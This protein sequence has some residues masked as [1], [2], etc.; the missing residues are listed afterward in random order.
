MTYEEK[1]EKLRQKIQNGDIE[2]FT[3]EEKLLLKN[4]KD[5]VINLLKYIIH[6]D[7]TM[8][9]IDQISVLNDVEEI[10]DKEIF[11][12]EERLLFIK[13]YIEMQLHEEKIYSSSFSTDI[14]NSLYLPSNSTEE[15]QE[16]FERYLDDPTFE[17]EACELD[18]KTI[19]SLLD[20][21]RYD[22]LSKTNRGRYY[23]EPDLSPNCIERLLTEFPTDQYPEPLF[24]TNLRIVNHYNYKLDT[25]FSKV[26]LD[27][28]ILFINKYSYYLYPMYSY[29]YGQDSDISVSEEIY[30]T[31]HGN[32]LAS[33]VNPHLKEKLLAADDLSFLNDIKE[34]DVINSIILE[35]F[36]DNEL[37][38]LYQKGFY[39]LETILR[40]Q[41]PK[42]LENKLNEII[43][44]G[45]KIPKEI[46]SV[47]NFAYLNNQDLVLKVLDQ[48]NLY[49][50]L[51]WMKN[52]YNDNPSFV[53]ELELKL[54]KHVQNNTEAYKE[55]RNNLDFNGYITDYL[56]LFPDFV[57]ETLGSDKLS[58]I[59]E[60]D[61]LSGFEY[62]KRIE[63]VKRI[64]EKNPNTFLSGLSLKTDY[65]ILKLCADA[66]MYD[67]VISSIAS[68]NSI[69]EEHKKDYIEMILNSL[70]DLSIA[71]KIAE[72]YTSLVMLDSSITEFFLSQDFTIGL[73]LKSPNFSTIEDQICT[74]DTFEK[75]KNNIAKNNNIPISHLEKME[76]KFGPNIIKYYKDSKIIDIL[77]LDDESFEKIMNLFPDLQLTLDDIHT[78]Y[79]ALIEKSFAIEHPEI[80]DIGTLFAHAI[81][82]S[83]YSE[84][85]KYKE[86]FIKETRLDYLQSFLKKENLN[87]IETTGELIDFIIKLYKN[88][89]KVRANNYIHEL[90]NELI[91]NS[92]T[93]YRNY[94]YL[95][96][97]YYVLENLF[98]DILKI[99]DEC[100]K[101]N[102]QIKLFEPN[103]NTNRNGVFGTPASLGAPSTI[104]V[105]GSYERKASFIL[106]SL[107]WKLEIIT[108]S[109]DRQFFKRLEK[110]YDIPEEYK[111]PKAFLEMVCQKIQDP[112]KRNKYLP[113][114]R[115][116]VYYHIE[117]VA[118]SKKAEIEYGRELNLPYDF[119]PKNVQTVMYKYI[120]KNSNYC[121]LDKQRLDDYIIKKCIEAGMEERIAYDCMNYYT[122]GKG[123][124]S[125]ERCLAAKKRIKDFITI[126]RKIIDEHQNKIIYK[127]TGKSI[128]ESKKEIIKEMDRLNLL[129]RIYRVPEQQ[130]IYMILRKLNIRLISNKILTNPELYEKLKEIIQKRK[131]HLFPDVFKDLLEKAKIELSYEDFAEFINYFAVIFEDYEREKKANNKNSEEE[132]SMLYILSSIQYYASCS[133]VYAQV[134]TPEDAKLIKTNPGPN[135][136]SSKIENDERSKEAVEWTVSNFRRKKVTIPT[137]DENITLSTEKKK[138]INVIVGNFTDHTNV[139]HGERTG[140]CM[141]I[142]GVGEDLFYFA[143]KN[144]NGFHIRFEDPETHEYVSRITGFRNGNTVVLNQLRH[145]KSSKYTDEDLMQFS[146]MVAEMLIEKSKNS[147]RPIEN[148]V[149]DRRYGFETY[150]GPFQSL[151]NVNLREGYTEIYSD[152]EPSNCIVL[153]TSSKTSSFVPVDTSKSNI[154]SYPTCR[155]KIKYSNN[156]EEIKINYNRILAVKRLLDGVP[157]EELDVLTL[158]N[159]IISAI[160]SD[161]WIILINN[162]KEL[163]YILIEEDPRAK[164]E[165]LDYLER[166]KEKIQNNEEVLEEGSI[167]HG[168]Q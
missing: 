110:I 132:M 165:L 71:K 13:K 122:H 9:T 15:I 115:E 97:M 83:N 155:G 98:E 88:G 26:S 125:D 106:D 105:I 162:Q 103:N 2:T 150:S 148:V 35:I 6:S 70:E 124:M 49:D 90:S 11:T 149:I 3:D 51:T 58:T 144:D 48:G 119:E 75:I 4:E 92:R 104:E 147:S 29:N 63:I 32:E 160:V 55:F 89:E 59:I 158:P 22:I 86:I 121:Y 145:S 100:N 73:L 99:I 81:E 94:H 80:R 46:L 79:T 61:R 45:E 78:T 77:Q 19:L 134:L 154:P 143:L 102:I 40:R 159:N 7:Q 151:G 163:Q 64:I 23:G 168:I 137:F 72:R 140:A 56:S 101:K 87:N 74:H 66:H 54:I 82:D 41:Q 133:S 131:L 156:I 42:E 126:A 57:I 136:A 17:F 53:K 116:A 167:L 152:T 120:I 18:E 36:N 138:T 50:V 166:V 10:N 24:I 108:S 109:L 128:S 76:Q 91:R 84:I 20:K 44:K 135:S 118:N 38:I 161:D 31:D 139:T 107:R 39:R 47:M 129:Q 127:N 43:S 21:K 37:D 62:D 164:E 65:P 96:E 141:R 111:E 34:I 123:F 95:F 27:T 146:K 33:K 1:V 157:L 28:L 69:P 113:I 52:H 5:L 60:F 67:V 14:S 16:I 25:D 142:G 8:T 68:S 114:L 85:E 93:E 153:A 112:N 30:Y 12:N 130:D 117:K